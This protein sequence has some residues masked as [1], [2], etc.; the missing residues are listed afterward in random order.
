MDELINLIDISHLAAASKPF[1]QLYQLG[2]NY[3]Y[4][5]CQGKS[6]ENCE[7]SE[8]NQIITYLGGSDIVSER[9]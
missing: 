6:I 5:D 7:I 2:T 9:Y 4:I 3:S 8:K 1:F